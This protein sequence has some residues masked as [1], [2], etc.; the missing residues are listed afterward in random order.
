MNEDD[1]ELQVNKV[2]SFVNNEP[3][4]DKFVTYSANPIACTA[5][6]V[7]IELLQSEDIQL[8]LSRIK[9]LESISKSTLK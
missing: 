4:I 5:A 3:V 6:L 2:E 8:L 9:A 1:R 7:S